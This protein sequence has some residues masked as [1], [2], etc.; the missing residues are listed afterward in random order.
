MPR[1]RRLVAVLT[2]QNVLENYPT[3]LMLLGI[4]SIHRPIMA[5]TF[6]AIRLAGF[7][8]YVRGYRVSTSGHRGVDGWP[9]KTGLSLPGSCLFR[10]ESRFVISQSG[11][12]SA[13]SCWIPGIR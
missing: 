11:I 8:F 12:V 3:F 9:P 7:V 4:S 5:A 10:S 13:A 2:W 1:L 6:G